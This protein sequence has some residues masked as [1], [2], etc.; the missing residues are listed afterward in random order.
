M[1]TAHPISPTSRTRLAACALAAAARGWH[2][3]PLTMHNKVP[4]KGFT[5]W[6]RHVTTDP[7]LIRRIWG[8]RP[9]NIG[10]ATGPSGLVVLDLD[11]PKPGETPPPAWDRPGVNDGADVLALVCEEAGQPSPTLET[12]Q[13]RTRR[14]GTHLY[15]TAPPGTTLGNTAGNRGRGLGWLIDTRGSGGYVVGPGSYVDLPDGTGPYEVINPAT[16]APLPAWLATRL[17]QTTPA[18]RPAG[19]SVGDVLAKTGGDRAA[20]YALGALRGEIDQVLTAQPGTRN[21][22]LNA[23]A[24]ALGLLTGGGLLPRHLA[25]TTLQIAA[26]IIGLTAGE[27]FATIRSG[28]DSGQRQPRDPA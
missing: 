28:L 21:D 6:E 25:E 23:A 15:Y 9:Y 7:E 22:T 20:G 18:P 2:V 8:R 1:T 4:L 17:T 27:A 13:V 12:F 11:T 14:G 5:D 3:F 24:F 19:T 10:I 26:E 16:P